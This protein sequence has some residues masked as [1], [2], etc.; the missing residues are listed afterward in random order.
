MTIAGMAPSFSLSHIGAQR[1]L[2][3]L[4]R[5][6]NDRLIWVSAAVLANGLEVHVN[7]ATGDTLVALLDFGAEDS[8]RE[9]G[10]L[11]ELCFELHV[12]QGAALTDPTAIACLQSVS[13][14][15]KAARFAKKLLA[16]SA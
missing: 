9:N 2:R 7:R 3:V 8:P 15:G 14:D 12:A 5:G 13:G 1:F 11:L 16:L 6:K 10:G 4:P